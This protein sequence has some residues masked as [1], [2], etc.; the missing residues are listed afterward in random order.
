MTTRGTE[1]EARGGRT[2]SRNF[3][4]LWKGNDKKKLRQKAGGGGGDDL[5]G[6]TIKKRF[7]RDMWRGGIDC[8]GP[9][10]RD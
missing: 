1:K 10:R 8:R 2:R 9:E 3:V 4:R 5:A 7:E 6:P